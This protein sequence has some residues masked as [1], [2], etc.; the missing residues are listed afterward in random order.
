MMT[1][2]FNRY[3][4]EIG[5]YHHLMDETDY[6]TPPDGYEDERWQAAQER[7][8]AYANALYTRL[9]EADEHAPRKTD[10]PPTAPKDTPPD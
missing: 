1:S 3:T 4:I 2:L 5:G 10:G 6:S 7:L 8:D 9:K